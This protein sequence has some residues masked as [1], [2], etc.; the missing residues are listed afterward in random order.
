MPRSPL[1]D[2]RAG[3]RPRCVRASASAVTSGSPFRLRGLRY[4]SVAWAFASVVGQPRR[5]PSSVCGVSRPRPHR[6]PFTEPSLHSR[7][8]HSNPLATALR[9]LCRLSRHSPPSHQALRGEAWVSSP[10][11]CYHG[12]RPSA[13]PPLDP[14]PTR[15]DLRP[16]RSRGLTAVLVGCRRALA[17]L[18]GVSGFRCQPEHTPAC[19]AS[20]LLSGWRVPRARDPFGVNRALRHPPTFLA[21]GWLQLRKLR[22]F[23]RCGLWFWS[24]LS[25]CSNADAVITDRHFCIFAKFPEIFI[26]KMQLN[27]VKV[28]C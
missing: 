24:A 3:F 22:F 25:R 8:L 10:A 17:G 7:H 18:A 26:A 1:L 16:P 14:P 20:A 5:P 19:P 6:P 27:F 13:P 28:L 21:C 2:V 11:G 4:G 9:L 15:G 12:G 23:L